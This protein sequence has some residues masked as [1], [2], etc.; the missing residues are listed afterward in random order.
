[1]E[2]PSMTLSDN[3]V[4]FLEFLLGQV[5]KDALLA[6][7]PTPISPAIVSPSDYHKLPPSLQVLVR[8]APVFSP[9]PKRGGGPHDDQ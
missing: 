5:G 1:M 9:G 4:Q 2:R 7:G 3:G 8:K 6:N